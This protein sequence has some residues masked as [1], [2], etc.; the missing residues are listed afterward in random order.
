M[1]CTDVLSTLT[2]C[3]SL[4]LMLLTTLY[5]FY[6]AREDAPNL[7]AQSDT[8]PSITLSEH[9][10]ADSGAAQSEESDCDASDSDA[11][12]SPALSRESAPVHDARN[13]LYTARLLAREQLDRERREREQQALAVART[14]AASTRRYQQ[15]LKR[16]EEY[17]KER[18]AAEPARRRIFAERDV[19]LREGRMYKTL[20]IPQRAMYDELC[21]ARESHRAVCERNNLR[22]LPRKEITLIKIRHEIA[23]ERDCQRAHRDHM[24]SMQQQ[25]RC[26][27][28]LV[29]YEHALGRQLLQNPRFTRYFLEGDWHCCVCGHHTHGS[30]TRCYASCGSLCTHDRC[31]NCFTV[32]AN[33]TLERN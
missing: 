29:L 25:T 32:T 21:D 5:F 6:E 8:A 27:C 18:F 2:A 15:S 10:V 13:K 24:H 4:L 22:L 1:H 20:T 12:V 9:S 17:R 31:V 23:L 16:A 11:S 14:R 7:T 26:T 3:C 33:G 28:G 19:L 30:R